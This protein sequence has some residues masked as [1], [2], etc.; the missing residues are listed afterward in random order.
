MIFII[1]KSVREEIKYFCDHIKS[2]SGE[3]ETMK[4]FKEILKIYLSGNQIYRASELAKNE[5]FPKAAL[6]IVLFYK[7]ISTF[8]IIFFISPLYQIKTR[9]KF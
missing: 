9:E 1:S 6:A 3:Q 4:C 7:F 8:I 2:I 5:G